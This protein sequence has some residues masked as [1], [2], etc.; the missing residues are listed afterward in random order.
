MKDII[1]R[2][3]DE[4]A[5]LQKTKNEFREQFELQLCG[6]PDAVHIYNNIEMASKDLSCE[7]SVEP[8]RCKGDI[9]YKSKKSFTYNGVLFF[10]LSE[11][12]VPE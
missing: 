1:D 3:L 2:L 7:L 9:Q 4:M 11:Q 10:E 12:E 5:A 8:F 6:I